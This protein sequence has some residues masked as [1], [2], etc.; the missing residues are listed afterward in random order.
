MPDLTIKAAG[1]LEI[2]IIE[3]ETPAISVIRIAGGTHMCLSIH[4]MHMNACIYMYR[5][6]ESSS[7]I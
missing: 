3:G 1:A 4:D 2:R 6:I 7:D 5:Y